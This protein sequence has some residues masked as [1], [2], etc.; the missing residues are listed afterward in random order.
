MRLLYYCYYIIS[1]AGQRSLA[2]SSRLWFIVQALSQ[3]ISPDQTAPKSTQWTTLSVAW[4]SSPLPVNELKQYLSDVWYG[5][6]QSIID[7]VIN[8]ACL[9][10]KGNFEQML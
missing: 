9:R 7:S 3:F 5:M 2:H 4:P 6:E 1:L 8:E 10:L